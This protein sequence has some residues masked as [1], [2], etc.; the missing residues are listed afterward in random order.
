L[1]HDDDTSSLLSRSCLLFSFAALDG[2]AAVLFTFHFG[3][4]FCAAPV[5]FF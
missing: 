5:F 4:M 1:A 2:L 3:G